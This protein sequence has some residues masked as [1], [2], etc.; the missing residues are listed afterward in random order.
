M[1]HHWNAVVANVI[2]AIVVAAAAVVVV[3][4]AVAFGVIVDF[5]LVDW[6]A[7]IRVVREIHI[8]LLLGGWDS[9]LVELL[10][11]AAC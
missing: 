8:L 4:A 5:E 6:V 9:N 2:V 11:E 3:V 7:R 10:P 1:L